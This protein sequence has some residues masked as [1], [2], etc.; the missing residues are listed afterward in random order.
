MIGFRRAPGRALAFGSLG[1]GLAAIAMIPTL[2][3][4]GWSLTALPRVDSR[5]SLGA[6]A[7]RLDPGFHTFHPGAYDGQFYWGIAVDPLATGAL[8]EDF[9]KASYR[10]GHPLYGWLGWLLSAD[11][12]RAVPASLA[13]VGLAALF[14]GAAIAAALGLGRGRSGWEALFV[15]LNP[16]LISAATHDLAEPLGAALLLGALAA[17]LRGRMLATW[18]CLALLPLAKEPLA[19]A[20][21]AL[22]AW[23]LGH[24]RARRAGLLASAV[25][26]AAAW[27]TYTRVHFGAWFTS[28]DT[29]LGRPFAGWEQALVGSGID[30]HAS[31]SAHAAALAAL[32]ALLAVLVLA[33]LRALRLRGP[34]DYVYLALAA[35]AACLAPNAT[36]ELSTALRNTAFLVVLAPFVIASPPLLPGCARG[37]GAGAASPRRPGL[38]PR[39][40]APAG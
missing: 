34:V 35:V 30:A 21:L 2:R 33:A 19:L 23:E 40:R 1:V 4:A 15:A 14:A 26:P 20:L 36:L 16:G 24:R 32:V 27:W 7:R 28:G 17:Y 29:A 6:A 3:S 18:C 22:A 8:H 13:A 25:L 9:D 38:A 10:Y 12:V 31:A 5:T 11:R 39:V 37:S